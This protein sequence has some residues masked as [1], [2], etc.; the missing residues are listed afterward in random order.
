MRAEL[1]ISDYYAKKYEI[2]AKP[3]ILYCLGYSSYSLL[4]IIYPHLFT[5]YNK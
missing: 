5:F 4:V 3:F 2:E 1:E